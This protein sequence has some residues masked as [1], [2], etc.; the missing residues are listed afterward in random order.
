MSKSNLKKK[1]LCSLLAAS[2][3][4]VM[5]NP[6]AEAAKVNGHDL[7]DLTAIEKTED[8]A[9]II[10]NESFGK[11]EDGKIDSK[12]F[13]FGQGDTI[14]LVTKGNVNQLIEDLQKAVNKPTNEEKV[15]AIREALAKNAVVGVIGGEGQLDSGLRRDPVEVDD[16]KYS[17]ILDL[18]NDQMP[19]KGFDKIIN[20]DTTGD[21]DDVVKSGDTAIVIGEKD[22]DSDISP[23]VIG[24]VGGDLSVNSGANG[25]MLWGSVNIESSS[26][27]I[28]RNGN[29]NV[30]IDSGNVF[31][32]VGGSAAVAVGKIEA[33]FAYMGVLNIVDLKFNGETTTTING[34][35]NLTVNGGANVAG[36]ANGGLAMGIGGKATSIVNGNSNIIIDSNVKTDGALDG[37]TAGIAG[38][39]AAV[40]TIGGTALTEV[41]NVNISVNNGLSAGI[42]GGGMAAAVDAA[43]LLNVGNDDGTSDITDIQIEKWLGMEDGGIPAGAITINGA[44]EGGNATSKTGD[45]NLVFT[46]NTTAAGVMGGGVAVASHTYT[47]RD[48]TDGSAE[49]NGTPGGSSTATAETG[50]AH[51]VVNL[52]GE[53]NTT[54]LV[55][56]ASGLKDALSNLADGQEMEAIGAI[57]GALEN[58]DGQSSVIGLTGGGMAVAHGDANS[59]ATTI[60]AGADI[61]LVDG[62]AAGVF[63]GGIAAANSNAQAKAEM[64]DDININIYKDMEAVGVFGNGLAY[65]TGKDGE[66][67]NFTGKAEVTAINTNIN[68]VGMADGVVGG[69]VAIDDTSANTTNASV[70]TSGK[71]TIN[72]VDGEVK[73][74]NF[75][76][77]VILAGG[78]PA[79]DIDMGSYVAALK[80]AA[81]NIAIAGGGVAIGGGAESTVNEA[82][83]NIYGG[84][85][86][87]NIIGGGVAVYGYTETDEKAKGA[88]VDNATINLYGGTVEGN[89]YAGGSASAITKGGSGYDKAI[90]TVDKAVINLAGTV[91]KGTISGQGVSGTVADAVESSTLNVS[92]ENTLAATET[93]S[94]I[95]GF[96][97]IEFAAD[98]VTKLEKLKAGDTTALIDGQLEEGKKSVITV[99]DS[100]RLDISGLE[101]GN[102]QNGN[103]YFVAD[104]YDTA[105]SHLWENEQ[106]AYDRTAGYAVAKEDENGDYKVTYKDLSKLTEDEQKDAVNDAVN[107]FGRFGGSARGIIEGIVRDGMTADET[108]SNAGAKDFISDLTSS[109]NQAEV[110]QGIYTGMM[111]GE[112]SG[113]TSNAVSMAQDFADNAL[114]R[115]S[116]TQDTVNADKVGEEGGVWAKYLHNKHEVD[117]M[118]SSFGTLSSS[119]D[120]DGVMVGA[121]L[122]KKGNMQAGIAFAYGEGDGNGLTTKNDF[123]MWGISLYGNVKNDDVNIIGD[124]GFSKSSNEITGKVSGGELNTDRDLNIFTMGVRAEKLYTNGNTQIVP[125]AGLRY[126][127]VDADSYSTTYK[128]GKAFDYDA[129]RQNIWTLPLG[130]SLRNETVTN[131][132]WTITPKVDLAYIWAFGDTDNDVTVNAGSGASVLSYDVMDSGSWLASVGV[133]AGKGDWSYG[134]SYTLQKGSDVENNKWF[135]NVNYSF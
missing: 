92:G 110:E 40:T 74:L 75:D 94:K 111:I 5:Y 62:Y 122:A 70:N 60:T 37:I 47:N 66:I 104:N 26:T 135:V 12:K 133:D 24:V 95:S 128:D 3:F 116:F 93:G 54:E 45:T 32:G 34:D 13:I 4:G 17:G 131:S 88:H 65:L 50:K 68:I 21:I 85:V 98:S 91:V 99:A 90:A 103:T 16:K 134:L 105:K 125:Y 63:G 11:T 42:I 72:V 112:D 8:G 30:Q 41:G 73:E 57:K 80:D 130:V 22:K 89:V 127:S 7:N 1:V 48:T 126:M 59:S 56:V 87:N 123:D 107:S 33:N 78:A 109:D 15:A 69:G 76:P 124:L 82:E 61:D 129:E 23:V 44:I 84:T 106:L 55:G 121:E 118:N 113:V 10:T 67:H 43:G 27:S 97:N 114:L 58:A 102:D 117:G 132:G 6:G 25:S 18:V 96:D 46:G 120:Y 83:I 77:L 39:G 38:G 35:S 52:D 119:S 9:F 2:V 20:V 79:D 49:N 14:K 86:K 64:K 71:A 36:W 100:A 101:K 28:T 108:T 81:G 31:G 53:H 19:G 29:T 51:I 115:L